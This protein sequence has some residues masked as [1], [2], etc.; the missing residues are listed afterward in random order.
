MEPLWFSFRG[1][2]PERQQVI[3]GL[4]LA[5]SQVTLPAGHLLPL[6]Q[7]ES[8]GEE[9]RYVCLSFVFLHHFSLYKVMFSTSVIQP[10]NFR[11]GIFLSQYDADIYIYMQ[12][13]R[14]EHRVTKSKDQSTILKKS[15]IF[16]NFNTCVS[17]L[18]ISYGGESFCSLPRLP[19]LEYFFWFFS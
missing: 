7:T 2:Y 16:A 13:N 19:N 8:K 18:E 6:S 10:W 1:N 11:L 14:V 12:Q 9:D 15:H 5:S 17:D 3:L 4:A